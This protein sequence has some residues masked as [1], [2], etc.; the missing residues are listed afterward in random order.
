M[1]YI[2]LF[3]NN[4]L[5]IDKSTNGLD[6]ATNK[7][8]PSRNVSPSEFDTIQ[9]AQNVALQYCLSV[10]SQSRKTAEYLARFTVLSTDELLIKGIIE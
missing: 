1:K 6:M 4:P 3:D 5:V 9:D 10:K 8:N 7:Y 2:L